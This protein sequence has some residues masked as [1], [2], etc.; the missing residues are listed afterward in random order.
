M[1]RVPFND[2]LRYFLDNKEGIEQQISSTLS[3]GRW[4]VGK[5]TELF[6]QRFATYCGSRYCLTVANGTDALELCLRVIINNQEQKTKNEIIT[7]AN[8]GG[9]SSIACRLVGAVPVYADIDIIS[10]LISV[11]S[12]EN[13][14]GPD[15]KAVILTHLYGSVVDVKAVR[16][17][18]DKNGYQHVKIIEDCAQAHGAKLN[19]QVVGSLGD[20]AAFSFYPTKN[21]GAM[22][23]AGAITTSNET[24]FEQVKSLS[25]YGWAQKYHIN[26]PN[27]RNSRM[28]EIQAAILNYQLPQLE[29]HNN[30]RKTIYRRY[31]NVS[32]KL[33]PITSIEDDLFV[34]HLAVF[35]IQERDK[36]LN[37]CAEKGVEINIHYPILDF[38]QKAWRS[39]D[40][41]TDE[42]TNMAN[43]TQSVNEIVSL[44]C[45]SYLT[46]EEIESVCD[47]LTK[48][49]S[50]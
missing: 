45:F 14:L 25:Q 21:L 49:D 6:S 31:R 26:A 15:V 47:V 22:G 39:M 24:L 12:I 9:Y 16:K 30:I 3:S 43:S 27:G 20:L 11:N 23:D 37:F 19:N 18:L 29:R 7:V 44:P 46:T 5:Q 48:W 41:R 1:M 38:N 33:I 35:R 42:I 40:M 8:A 50:L 34:A 2:T 32:R 36:F 10:Q 28:D 17:M 13:C 4:L